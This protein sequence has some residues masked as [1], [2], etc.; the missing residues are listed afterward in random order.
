MSVAGPAPISASANADDLTVGD[1]VGAR[2]ISVFSAN[3]LS[4]NIYFADPDSATSGLLRYNHFAD[5]FEIGV[6]GGFKFNLEDDN[7]SP[8][9]TNAYDI[10]TSTYAWRTGY[11]ET[12]LLVPLVQS[13]DFGAGA[14]SGNPLTV[15]AGDGGTS[16]SGSDGGDL[17]IRAG[18]AQAGNSAGGTLALKS[19]ASNGSSDAGDIELSSGLAPGSGA[20]LGVV[21]I[22][23]TG[24]EIAESASTPGR[25]ITAGN[26]RYWVEDTTPS[27][28]KFT[29]DAGGEHTF[30]YASE[31]IAQVVWEQDWAALADSGVLADGA[32]DVGGKSFTL[33][34]SANCGTKQITNGAGLQLTHTAGTNTDLDNGI[35]SGSTGTYL[36]IPL[37][38]LA[39][40]CAQYGKRIRLWA[41]FSA[42]S[43]PDTGN[44]AVF[45]IGIDGT[46]PADYTV[47]TYASQLQNGT[48][49]G[50]GIKNGTT[51]V[52]GVEATTSDNVIVFDSIADGIYHVYY[53]QWS[54]G[55]P[56]FEDLRLAGRSITAGTTGNAG[57]RNPDAHLMIGIATN[58]ASGS[59]SFTL[60][61]T[62][63]EIGG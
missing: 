13:R 45:G 37:N 14:G 51:E 59:P 5:R 39:A 20:D 54:S 10:G 2:G 36:H 24:L 25:A 52:V 29:D 49:D 47:T 32:V 40:E 28:P 35:A 9:L 43:V 41:Y 42:Y 1:G 33:V 63:I 4:G 34:N 44:Q 58:S 18:D 46:F 48:T 6:A 30:A 57:W 38:T 60:A 17:T 21:R 61:R 26:G 7:I 19:G 3:N 22:T 50:P 11:F 16:G 27:T 55:W 53:G 23:N 12:S 31:V 15:R 56:A 62:K 8:L